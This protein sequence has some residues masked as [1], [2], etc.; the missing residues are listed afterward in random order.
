ML[1]FSSHDNVY[2]QLYRNIYNPSKQGQSK[3]ILRPRQ[4]FSSTDMM[5]TIND[6]ADK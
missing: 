6:E 5:K 3:A 4:V 1:Y 2:L